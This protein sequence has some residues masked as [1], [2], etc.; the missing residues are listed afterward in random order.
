VVS[1]LSRRGFLG[2][3]CAGLALQRSHAAANLEI[4]LQLSSAAPALARDFA[5]TLRRIANA[6]YRHV[7][8]GPAQRSLRPEALRKALDEAGLQCLSVH[9]D[10]WDDSAET[11]TAIDTATALGFKYLVTAFPARMTPAGLR[12]TAGTP[13]DLRGLAR[14]MTMNDWRWNV[15]WFNHVGGMAQKANLQFVYHNHEFEFR[16]FD[17]ATAFDELLLRT[18]PGRVKVELDCAGA[19]AAGVDPAALLQRFRDRIVLLHLSDPSDDRQRRALRAAAEAGVRY[20]YVEREADL[21][22][23]HSLRAAFSAVLP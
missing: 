6:G 14:D 12:P 19:I 1:L 16:K 2:A 13:E 20:A 21:E 3:A 18:D 7:E 5:G 4:G 9:W 11:D 22:T 15:D 10:L 17:G 23:L 8:L